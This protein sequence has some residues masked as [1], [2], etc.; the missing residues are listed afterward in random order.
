M[1]SYHLRLKNDSKPNGQKISAKG[2]ADYILR[3]DGKAHADYINREG[4]QNNKDDCVFEYSQLPKWA[5]GSAQ[6]FF[7][8][9]TRYEDKGNRR[10]KEIELSLPNELNLEQNHEIVDKFIANHLS[11]HYYAYAIHDKAGELSGERHPHVHIMFSERLID[12]VEN[13]SE[14]PAYKYFRRSAKPLKGEQVASFQRRRDHGAPK[15]KKWHDKNYLKEL[16]ADFAHIQNEVLAKHGFSVRVDH[17][18]LQAQK[19]EAERNGDKILAQV[20]D[21]KPEKYIGVM[22]SHL[23]DE[24]VKNL[25]SERMKRQQQE[26]TIFQLDFQKKITL[27]REVQELVTQVEMAAFSCAKSKKV[28]SPEM[29]LELEQIKNLKKSWQKV[30]TATEKVLAEYL[31]LT[32]RKLLIN[33]KSKMGELLNLETLMKKITCPTETQVQNLQAYET[34]MQAIAEKIHCLNKDLERILPKVLEVEATLDNVGRRKNIQQVIHNNLQGNLEKLEQLKTH[35]TTLLEHVNNL[36]QVDTSKVEFKRAFSFSEVERITKQ[37]YYDLKT[38]YE[39][40][41]AERNALKL[42]VISASRAI[43]MA[44]NV[45]VQGDFK[46]LRTKENQCRKLSKKYERYFEKYQ[47]QEEFFRVTDWQD[48]GQRIQA[49]YYLTKDRIHLEGIRRKIQMM[50]E[51]IKVESADLERRCGTPQAKQKIGLIAA[52]ILSKNLKYVREYEKSNQCVKEMSKIVQ[53]FKKRLANLK[54]NLP[55]KMK[56]CYYQ[57]ISANNT[58]SQHTHSTMA[59]LVSIIAAALNHEPAAMAQVV[60]FSGDDLLEKDWEWLTEFEKDELMIKKIIRDL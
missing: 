23:G 21:R 9:A 22:S 8:A 44:K 10:Y 48:D 13:V 18:T 16:R 41:V 17:R 24:S 57:V 37:H 40:K 53:L 2:H 49:H 56:K 55:K 5:K 14:R 42:K 36:E 12:D 19:E 28:L 54:E 46:E 51:Q 6:K 7:S 35:S 52:R 45:F 39:K 15:D 20:Y 11:N 50:N 1:A 58:A 27:E 29:Q 4:A 3:E 30:H 31:T 59:A 25:L 38:Q 47:Q 26:D 60:C 43:A 33:F 34:I 32:E